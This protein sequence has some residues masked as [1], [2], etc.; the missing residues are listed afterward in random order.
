MDSDLQLTADELKKVEWRT[1]DDKPAF[2]ETVGDTLQS[3]TNQKQGRA[4]STRKMLLA[5]WRAAQKDLQRDHAL[6]PHPAKHARVFRAANPGVMTFEKGMKLHEGE[7]LSAS[8][9]ELLSRP[10]RSISALSHPKWL[11]GAGEAALFPKPQL[12]LM[13]ATHPM[14]ARI[15]REL[16]V[17]EKDIVSHG[18]LKGPRYAEERLALAAYNAKKYGAGLGAWSPPIHY[19]RPINPRIFQT[20]RYLLEKEKIVATRPRKCNHLQPHPFPVCPK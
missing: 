15:E 5:S 19:H 11:V 1:Y 16:S 10:D 7:Y 13:G 3:L 18:P 20:V 4:E 14:K 2:T 9:K 17:M 12:E 6:N 8:Q